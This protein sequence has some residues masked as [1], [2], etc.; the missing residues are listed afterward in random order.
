MNSVLGP[1]DVSVGTSI[2]GPGGSIKVKAGDTGGLSSDGGSVTITAGDSLN[3]L[4][5]NGGSLN[6]SSGKSGWR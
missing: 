5:G 6:F 3:E 1:I 4:G 2:K